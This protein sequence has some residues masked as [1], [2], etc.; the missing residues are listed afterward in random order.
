VLTKV[1][2]MDAGTDAAAILRNEVLPLAL[3]Y[4]AWQYYRFR[5]SGRTYEDLWEPVHLKAVPP[6]VPYAKGVGRP[7]AVGRPGPPPEASAPE[8]FFFLADFDEQSSTVRAEVA[9]SRV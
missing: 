5:A 9:G 1:D 2:L 8:D 7:A 3:G 4:A 6:R